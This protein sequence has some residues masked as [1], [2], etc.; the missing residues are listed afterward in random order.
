MID[1]LA[2]EPALHIGDNETYLGAL[3]NDTMYRHATGRG[4]AHALLEVRNDLIETPAGVLEWTDRLE[5]ILREILATPDMHTIR[6]YG[7][8]ADAD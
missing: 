6:H 4:L 7:S 1:G 8:L 5:P 2:A 3:K